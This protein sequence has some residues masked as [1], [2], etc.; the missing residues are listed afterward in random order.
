M[1][2]TRQR[3]SGKGGGANG[4]GGN[5]PIEGANSAEDPKTGSSTGT[6]TAAIINAMTVDVEDYFQVWAFSGQIER[7]DWDRYPCRVERNVGVVLQMFAE[8]NVHATFFVLGWVAKRYPR[9]IRDIVE[10]GHELASHGFEHVRVHEQTVNEFRADVRRTK[11]VLEDLGDTAVRGYRAASFS[12]SDATPWAF[13]VLA[14]EGYEYSSSIY[15][16]RHDIYGMPAAPRFAY[17]PDGQQGLIE[18]PVTTFTLFGQKLPCGGGGYFRILPYSVSR[19]AMRRVHRVDG[20]PC[21]FY[22]HPWEIDPDQPRFKGISLKTRIRHYTNL[23][24]MERR[25]RAVLADFTWDRI[26]RVFDIEGP[27]TNA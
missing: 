22:F 4:A 8:N 9:V 3:T 27:S 12:I 21:I 14:E 11:Q 2:G 20:Q 26:D 13:E 5:I 15:P 24:R 18:L 16:I 7:G 19:W 17:R 6:E 25:L 23:R 10:A 1:L